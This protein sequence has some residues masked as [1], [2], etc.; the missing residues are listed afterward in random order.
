[1]IGTFFY[2]INT[3]IP[4]YLKAYLI[5]RMIIVFVFNLLT[6]ICTYIAG[7]RRKLLKVL[8]DPSIIVTFLLGSSLILVDM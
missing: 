3:R 4:H 7:Y 8:H 5:C 1:M 2:Y 6:L